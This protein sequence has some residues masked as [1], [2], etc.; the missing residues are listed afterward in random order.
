MEEQEADRDRACFTMTKWKLHCAHFLLLL[1]PQ[2]F[3]AS[4]S[5]AVWSEVKLKTDQ[6][7]MP[8]WGNMRALPARRD[9]QNY[10]QKKNTKWPKRTT[11]VGRRGRRVREHTLGK[12]KVL[13]MK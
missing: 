1:L 9:S 5:V 11:T 3:V 13:C 4:A 6:R 8:Q 7:K 12:S 10:Y 2:L